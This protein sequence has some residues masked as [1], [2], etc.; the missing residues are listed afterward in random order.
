MAPGRAF[1]FAGSTRTVGTGTGAGAEGVGLEPPITEQP[2]VVSD[3][4]AAEMRRLMD[5][6]TP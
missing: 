2:A 1:K 3:A 4:T 5:R 6:F